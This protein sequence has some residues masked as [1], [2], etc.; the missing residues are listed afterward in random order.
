MSCKIREDKKRKDMTWKVESGR[1]NEDRG[2]I[3]ALAGGRGRPGGREGSVS[4]GKVRPGRR[5]C[6]GRVPR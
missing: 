4:K 6:V 2:E 3:R 5:G 1:F